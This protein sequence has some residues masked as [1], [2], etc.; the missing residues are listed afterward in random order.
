MKICHCK[1]RKNNDAFTESFLHINVLA[2]LIKS[3]KCFRTNSS[4]GDS[5]ASK[6]AYTNYQS[7]NVATKF[8]TRHGHIQQFDKSQTAVFFLLSML[9][10]SELF[11]NMI[12][13]LLSVVPINLFLL[14]MPIST[15][16]Q[17]FH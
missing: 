10:R 13:S 12:T 9:V 15:L 16:H 8:Y 6:V 5:Y 17:Q 7:K 1:E 11:R 3:L 4:C 14:W 2:S